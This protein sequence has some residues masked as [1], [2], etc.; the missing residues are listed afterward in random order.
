MKTTLLIIL[1]SILL[2]F[3]FGQHVQP[4]D[5]GFINPTGTYQLDEKTKIKNGDTFG[6]FG[7]IKV[8]LID[9]KK[10][11]MSFYI[12]KGAPSY[13]SGSFVDTM[14]YKNNIVIYK[15][16]GDTAKGCTTTFVFSKLGITVNEKA[17][18]DMGTCW[19]AGVI[20]HGF[21]KKT[22]YKEPMIKDP[23]EE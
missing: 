3:N 4:N 22:S 13:N 16:K 19:G 7:D 2:D 18:Y 17:N 6:Y 23:L 8:K 9:N 15:D 20:A 1:I 14:I 12:C 10:V 11:V 5:N 21:Y